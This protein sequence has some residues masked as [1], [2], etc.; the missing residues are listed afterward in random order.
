[1]QHTI[2][3]GNTNKKAFATRRGAGL[4]RLERRD[5]GLGERGLGVVRALVVAGGDELGRRAASGG[6]AG[7]GGGGGRGARG[8]RLI[9]WVRRREFLTKGT[10][11]GSPDTIL[12]GSAASEPST[13]ADT[14]PG[15]GAA[16]LFPFIED[17]LADQLGFAVDKIRAARVQMT[18]GVHFIREKR[19][20]RWSEAG[21]ATGLEWLR[22]P[23]AEAAA[24]SGTPPA[25]RVEKPAL[26]TPAAKATFT[27]TNM[28]IP[29]Q[30]LLLCRDAAGNGAK[31]WIH[32]EWRP[33]FTVGMVIEATQGSSGDWRSRKPRSMGRF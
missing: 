17:D 8:G 21:L 11:M 1:M 18:Q 12:D 19:R 28:R 14:Q 6:A 23:V 3:S 20:F 22:A 32:P 4:V 2:S 10:S 30:H 5:L 27:V 26:V 24:V 33:L 16:V 25:A 7:G 29:N 13:Q 31:V 15:L 9:R